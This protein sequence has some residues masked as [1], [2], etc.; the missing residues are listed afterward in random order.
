MFPLLIIFGVLNLGE[1]IAITYV[2][3]YYKVGVSSIRQAIKFT[4]AYKSQYK[5]IVYE[6]R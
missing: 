2:M 4:D 5:E 1:E 3:P 6:K